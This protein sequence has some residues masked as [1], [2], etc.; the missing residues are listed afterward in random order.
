V[1]LVGLSEGLGKKFIK[2]NPWLWALNLGI[3][4]LF[5]FHTLLNPHYNFL[6]AL[7]HGNTRLFIGVA[8]F[9]IG[10]A[11]VMRIF[12]SKRKQK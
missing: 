8:F 2:L 11:F 1:Q 12:F 5:F 7:Q 4:G 3:C 6:Q 10:V 9:F